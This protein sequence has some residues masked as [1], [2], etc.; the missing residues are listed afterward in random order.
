M[1]VEVGG[2]QVFYGAGSGKASTADVPRRPS[3]IFLHGAGFDHSVWVM[4]ARYFA[5]HNFNVVAPD[6]PGHGRSEGPALQSIEAMADWLA[7]LLQSIGVCGVEAVK[8]SPTTNVELAVVGHSMG[9]LVAMA[10]AERHPELCTRIALLGTSAPMRVGPP[11]L[12]AAADNDA[13]AYAMANTWSHVA[14]SGLGATANP[15]MSNFVSG[16]RWLERMAEDVYYADLAACNGFAMD[17]SLLNLPEHKVPVLVLAAE[18]DKMT[19]PAAG[20]RVAELI[21]DAQLV[22]IK[23]SGHSM[24]SENPNDVLD[25]LAKF[26]L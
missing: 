9:S 24:M 25:A 15:G 21:D 16:G 12:E 7:E 13:A 17:L 23:N 18:Q 26:I 14:A 10:F 8:D 19:P 5:R 3:V 4:P 1:Y 22:A 2:K 11:L 6:F 20:R